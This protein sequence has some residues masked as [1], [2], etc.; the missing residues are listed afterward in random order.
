V[1]AGCV[2]EKCSGG[3]AAGNGCTAR[4]A[5]DCGN[6]DAGCLLGACTTPGGPVF[7]DAGTPQVAPDDGGVLE[8]PVDAGVVS[9]VDAGTPPD[10]DLAM[11][12]TPVTPVTPTQNVAAADPT[13]K[14]GCTSAPGELGLLGL[15]L[16]GLA[17]RRA[18]R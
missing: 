14:G 1:G 12:G 13:V 16:L 10:E 8:V 17:R 5:L 18:G 2:D 15:A 7:V 6:L 11:G 9:P 4:Q 3:T